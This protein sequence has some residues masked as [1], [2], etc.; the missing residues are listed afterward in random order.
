MDHPESISLW[1][2]LQPCR[3]IWILD[4]FNIVGHWQWYIADC[5]QMAISKTAD[6]YGIATDVESITTTG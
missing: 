3:D 6:I 1:Q 2:L 5:T 4:W